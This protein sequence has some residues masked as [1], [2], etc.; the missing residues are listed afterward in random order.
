M[1]F[2]V[3]PLLHYFKCEQEIRQVKK[4]A[5]EEKKVERRYLINLHTVNHV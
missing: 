4:V 1:R 2:R 5:K 3:S